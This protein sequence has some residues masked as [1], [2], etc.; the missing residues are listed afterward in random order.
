MI[1]IKDKECHSIFIK[2]RIYQ[3]NITVLNLSAPKYIASKY[4]R[5]NLTELQGDTNK[6]I[7]GGKF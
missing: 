4:V 2:E 5:E 3:E 1:N 6:S 7:I